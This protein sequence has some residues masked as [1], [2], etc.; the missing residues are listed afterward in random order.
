MLFGQA[1]Y[2]TWVPT[3][4]YSDTGERSGFM[5][6][7]FPGGAGSESLEGTDLGELENGDT[8]EAV[9]LDELT[10]SAAD[11]ASMQGVQVPSMP[12]GTALEKDKFNGMWLK[13][14]GAGGHSFVDFDAFALAW[15]TDVTA[16][17]EG[18]SAVVP[19]FRKTAAALKA[20]WKK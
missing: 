13:F 18:R 9:P 2:S 19:I 12:V 14:A 11:L 17:E 3:S 15:N 7:V 16:M 5:R 1:K 6:S 8:S 10:Q 4:A 20:Y